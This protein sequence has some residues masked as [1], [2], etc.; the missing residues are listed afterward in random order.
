MGLKSDQWCHASAQEAFREKFGS[1]L[2]AIAGQLGRR[3]LSPDQLFPTAPL[4]QCRFDCK[5]GDSH[6]LHYG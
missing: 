3:G 1:M 2:S 6:T 4:C 5:K